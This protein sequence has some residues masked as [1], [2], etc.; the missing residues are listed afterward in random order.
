MVEVKGHRQLAAVQ[1]GVLLAVF[2]RGGR[3][4]ADGHQVTRGEDI[5]AHL[6]QELM[7]PRAVGIEAAAIPVQIAGKGLVF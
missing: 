2:Q 7:Y 4:L 1:R 5:A 3:H 6:L